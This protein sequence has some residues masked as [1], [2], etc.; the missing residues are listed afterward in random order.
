VNS[1]FYKLPPSAQIFIG[2]FLIHHNFFAQPLDL[3][4]IVKE[5]EFLGQGQ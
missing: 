5:D 2:R 1:D 4:A 3:D